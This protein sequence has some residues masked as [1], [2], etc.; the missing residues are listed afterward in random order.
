MINTLWKKI[1]SIHQRMKNEINRL[2]DV[3]IAFF[4]SFSSSFFSENWTKEKQMK[5]KL[6]ATKCDE[7]IR[8]AESLAYEQKRKTR[9]DQYWICFDVI[10]QD[11]ILCLSPFEFV[12]EELPSSLSW[13][14][15]ED[16][17]F[18]SLKKIEIN[19]NKTIKFPKEWIESSFT[20]YY[21]ESFD[22]YLNVYPKVMWC[23]WD[24]LLFN[25][26]TN[27]WVESKWIRTIDVTFTEY[28]VRKKSDKT[29]SIMTGITDRYFFLEEEKDYY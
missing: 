28:F 16:E 11:L 21:V 6:K 22:R 23:H 29:A 20:C 10:N 9:C 3:N 19:K 17:A 2:I 8:I 5:T 26:T 7:I 4:S 24:L 13:E 18:N 1:N 14:R 25:K 12:M 27:W 15:Y